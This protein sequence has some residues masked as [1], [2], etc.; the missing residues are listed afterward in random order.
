MLFLIFSYINVVRQSR[1]ETD[2]AGDHNGSQDENEMAPD[3]KLQTVAASSPWS[4]KSSGESLM[5]SS[6]QTK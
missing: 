4:S 1:G 2:P 6:V 5:L 3:H